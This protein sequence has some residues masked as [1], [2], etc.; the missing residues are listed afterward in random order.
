MAFPEKIWVPHSSIPGGIQGLLAWGPGWA[1]RSVPTHPFCV[2][3]CV[4]VKGAPGGLAELE[5]LLINGLKR[6]AQSWQRSLG[7]GAGCL[8][9]GRAETLP[10]DWERPGWDE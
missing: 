2:G 9:M 1:L 6:R 4:G 8:G 5:R 7:E 3:S 10:R